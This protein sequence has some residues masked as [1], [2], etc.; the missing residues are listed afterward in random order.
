MK[1]KLTDKIRKFF[2]Q[3]ARAD[4]A[5]S[6][7]ITGLEHLPSEL[8]KH[9]FNPADVST[10][11]LQDIPPGCA[12]P[13][14]GMLQEKVHLPSTISQKA[15]LSSNPRTTGQD[16]SYSLQNEVYFPQLL[17]TLQSGTPEQKAVAAE[18]LFNYTAESESARQR[19][20][21]AGVV[22][23]LIGLLQQGTDHGKM[24]AA[25]TLSSLTS[26]EDSLQQ[27]RS[28]GA[29]TALIAILQ[30]CPLL[31]CKKGAMRALGRLARNDDAA[32]DIVAA[33]GL[34]PIIALLSRSDS[35]LVRRC[36][37]ALYFIGADKDA[38]QQ[39]IG[40]AGALPH[41]L[42]LASSDSPDVQA[43]ATDVLK[44]LC[45]N[46]ACGQA[47]AELGGFEVLVGLV[48]G[49]LTSRAKV[50]V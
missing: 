18:A 17:L 34:G 48:Q 2:G 46:A 41:L 1:V 38:L 3:D 32:S 31:V 13:G 45:R 11:V 36:L 30:Q 22:Q 19:A 15:D 4:A 26:V 35:S 43:E 7:S 12:V 40:A 25:Y 39:A 33:N 42:S 24:Y 37:I 23:H 21:Q 44:V 27:M 47:L 6:E 20:T 5:S 8:G 10:S 16:E 9:A 14:S 49:G 29:I 28:L 50:C